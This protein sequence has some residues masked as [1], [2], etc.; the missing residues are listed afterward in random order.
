MRPRDPADTSPHADTEAAAPPVQRMTPLARAH[1]RSASVGRR[2]ASRRVRQAQRASRKP[3]RRVSVSGLFSW[4]VVSGMMVLGLSVVLYLFLTADAFYVDS[5]AV[6]GDLS[7][8]D[9]REVFRYSDVAR[10]HIFW[11]DPEVV[12]ARLESY[13][14]IANATVYTGWPPDA[15]QIIVDERRPVLTLEQG[16]GA[17]AVRLWVDVNGILMKQR[18]DLPKLLLLKWTDTDAMLERIPVSLVNG[19]LELRALH[20]THA[21]FQDDINELVYEKN[22]GLGY[23]DSRGWTAWFGDGQDI[24][25][26]LIVYD[27]IVAMVLEQ[28]PNVY[29]RAIIVSSPD[30]PVVSMPKGSW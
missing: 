9:T 16:E 26:K 8:L 7:Y 28:Y 18:E 29:P 19:A 25:T 5:I 11:I 6:G 21:A 17:E 30:R 14:N 13:P 1:A 20:D 10:E 24:R 4:R 23:K 3:R 22:K 27:A 12:E 15:V 2:R